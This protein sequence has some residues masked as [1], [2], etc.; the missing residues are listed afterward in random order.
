EAIDTA[1]GATLEAVSPRPREGPSDELTPA[2]RPMRPTPGA[3]AVTQAHE[4]TRT[5]PGDGTAQSRSAPEFSFR[6][7]PGIPGYEIESELGRGGMG[8]VY[9]ARQVV[10]NRTCAL[11]MV[12]A[13][14]HA[15]TEAGARFLAEAGVVAKLQHLNFVQIFHLGEHDGQPYFEMEYV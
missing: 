2:D 1:A 9:K 11:K 3:G 7:A 6:I 8:V 5:G 4:T 13:G 10:L 14:E 12:L 15:G